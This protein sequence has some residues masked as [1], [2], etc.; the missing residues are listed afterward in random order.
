MQNIKLNFNSNNSSRKNKTKKNNFDFYT[1]I[2][3][4]PA[5]IFNNVASRSSST[6]S[7]SSMNIAKKS[8][9]NNNKN[10][11]KLTKKR[12]LT[13]KNVVFSKK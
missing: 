11:I 12:T 10:K 8:N 13:L 7:K 9:K 2:I 6:N 3:H 4:K 1:N 5:N